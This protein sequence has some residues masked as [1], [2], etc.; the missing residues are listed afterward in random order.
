MIRMARPQD[1]PTLRAIASA[2]YSQYIEIMD[3]TPAP[4]LA[5]FTTQIATKQIHLFE[6]SGFITLYPKEPALFI[7]SIAVLPNAQGRGIGKAL[8][9]FADTNARALGLTSLELYTNAKMT[10]NLTLYP[11]L[12]FTQTGRRQENGYDRVYFQKHLT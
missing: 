10:E 4:M 7:E 8:M 5:D 12:G 2:A 11:H 6:S 3:Q 1:E 9:D